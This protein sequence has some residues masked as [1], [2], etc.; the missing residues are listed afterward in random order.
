MYRRHDRRAR[1]TWMDGEG[2]EDGMGKALKA[3]IMRDVSGREAVEREV[4]HTMD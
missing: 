3:Q 4:G 1:L 2:V